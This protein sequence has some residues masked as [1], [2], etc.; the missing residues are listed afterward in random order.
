MHFLAW[1]AAQLAH[2]L[3][4]TGRASP[5]SQ[6]QPSQ[7]AATT[8]SGASVPVSA[9]FLFFATLLQLLL[10]HL[11]TDTPPSSI[12]ASD[13]AT[14]KGT[15]AILPKQAA[16]AGAAVAAAGAAAAA[17][18]VKQRKG[19]KGR[20]Q[21][22][23]ESDGLPVEWAVAAQGAALLVKL[24]FCQGFHNCLSHPETVCHHI[25]LVMQCSFISNMLGLAYFSK[26]RLQLPT[27]IHSR[28]RARARAPPSI[29][30]KGLAVGMCGCIV[31]LAHNAV[32]PSIFRKLSICVLGP[33]L[34]AC[35]TDCYSSLRLVMPLHALHP[36]SV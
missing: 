17:T 6:Q 34:L 26:A 18:A 2:K 25:G 21:G 16:A 11:Q 29:R 8:T 23:Q 7:Q 31:S 4:R 10:D 28:A 32:L 36:H 1:L 14:V 19:P 30:V 22:L 27:L 3:K 35:S 33:V 20:F 5:S 13:A 9:D 24:S 15:P 12:T